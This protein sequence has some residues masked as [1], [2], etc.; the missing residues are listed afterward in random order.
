VEPA[1]QREG[2]FACK[3]ESINMTSPRLRVSSKRISTPNSM[4]ATLEE[5]LEAGMADT[6]ALTPIG[7]L[8]LSR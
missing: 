7:S 1:A 2:R 4:Q 6:L 8:I 3:V 5:V